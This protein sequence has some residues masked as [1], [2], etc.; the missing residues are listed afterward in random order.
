MLLKATKYYAT[1]YNKKGELL[2][3]STLNKAYLKFPAAIAENVLECLSNQSPI[4]YNEEIAFPYE[5]ILYENRYL[6]EAEYDESWLVDVA[7]KTHVFSDNWLYL[8]ILPTNNCN[9]SCIYCYESN[10]EESMNDQTENSILEFVKRNIKKYKNLRLNWFGGEPLL[11]KERVVR[12]SEKINEICKQNGVPMVGLMSTNGYE[13]DLLTFKRLIRSRIL[14]Y[15]ICLD[16]DS[17][18]H[19]VQRPHR[20]KEDSY[21][22]IFANLK[23]IKEGIKT[24][25]FKIGIRANM[26]PFVEEHMLSHLKKLAVVFGSDKRFNVYFQGVRDW[27]GERF[28]NNQ[29]QVIE[30]EEDYYRKWY[31]I[32]NAFGL[33]SAESLEFAPVYGLCEANL[34]NGYVITHDGKITKCSLAS[35]NDKYRDIN[36]IGYIDE[37]GRA[38]ICQEKQAKWIASRLTLPKCNDCYIYP[39]CC[40][41]SCPYMKNI[42]EKKSCLPIKEMLKAHLRCMDLKGKIEMVCEGGQL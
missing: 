7:H 16:G 2:L 35:Y 13:L 38:I 19:N 5:K 1:D 29:P 22:K 30:N 32:A 8:T 37:K 17:C 15:Q 25:T 6:Y 21:E 14:S 9:F 12:M 39:I 42:Q 33:N 4:N 28:K 3:M 41:G 18:T 40:G 31:D 26:T 27:G 23:Q 36:E 24:G 20:L 34:K 10:K 11:Q